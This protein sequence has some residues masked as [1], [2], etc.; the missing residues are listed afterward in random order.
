M[1]NQLD[2]LNEDKKHLELA[3]VQ[4]GQLAQELQS[5][6]TTAT[7]KEQKITGLEAHLKETLT[8]YPQKVKELESIIGQLKS[9]NH[10]KSIS[11]DQSFSSLS[12]LNIQV[13]SEKV[14][15]QKLRQ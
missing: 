12:D 2:A 10:S 8:F 6:K 3:V 7:Y 1:Q 9:E 13:K 15:N 5:T 4:N 14:E 11:I